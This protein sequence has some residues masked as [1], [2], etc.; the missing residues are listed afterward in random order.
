MFVYIELF[1]SLHTVQEEG[2]SKISQACS[3]VHTP[4][5]SLTISVVNVGCQE[6]GSD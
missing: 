2:D 3:I 1:N 5:P 4:E 6:G